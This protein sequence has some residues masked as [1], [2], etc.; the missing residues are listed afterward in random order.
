MISSLHRMPIYR[1]S[2]KIQTRALAMIYGK[3]KKSVSNCGRPTTIPQIMALIKLCL[4]LWKTN[5]HS[6]NYVSPIVEDQ[7]PWEWTP[8]M[9]IKFQL[10]FG[11]TDLDMR[12]LRHFRFYGPQCSVIFKSVVMMS[13]TFVHWLNISDYL[14]FLT[15]TCPT[16]PLTWCIVIYG[17]LIMFLLVLVIDIS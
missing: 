14:L 11:T 16:F 5:H 4:Q 1:H 10:L 2:L 8:T 6:T 13:A 12:P 3:K 15:I 9:Q 7:P 17:V